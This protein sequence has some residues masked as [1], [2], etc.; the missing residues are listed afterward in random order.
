MSDLSNPNLQSANKNAK[1]D[2][3]LVVV[4]GGGGHAKA[5]IELI[6]AQG[7]YSVAGILDDSL[8]LGSLLLGK[9]VLGG[10]DTLARLKEQGIGQVVNAVGGISDI[11]PR[12]AIYGR[13]Q[14]A[15]LTV[16]DVIHPRAWV[17]KSAQLQGGA[18]ILCNTYVGSDNRIGFGCLMNVGVIL[19]H[20]CVLGDYVNLS[21]GATL[22]GNVQVGARTRIGMG[23]TINLG[24]HIGC[25]VRIGNS[26]VIK[27]DVPD[28][29]VVHA[30]E[31]WPQPQIYLTSSKL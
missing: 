1:I 17:E 27:K 21:P 29:M 5:V 8:P 18:Q 26:A 19:S 14:A 20:D 16:P 24:I 22:A 9:P 25:D 23:V 3:R 7:K 10:G 6:E 11:R 2:P 13:I 30:G 15:G 4:Y 28:G 12:L 31:V